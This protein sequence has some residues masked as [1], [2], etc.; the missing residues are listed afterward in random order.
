MDI[1]KQ[2]ISIAKK[3]GYELIYASR[4]DPSVFPELRI[5]NYEK[6]HASGVVSPCPLRVKLISD[7]I[8]PGSTVLDVGCGEGLIAE[9]ISRKKKVDFYG[10]DVSVHA[11][12]EF[13]KKGFKGEV[14]DIEAEGLNLKTRY[15]YI[16]FVEVLE[17]IKLPQKVLIEACEQARKGVI[18]T[19][20]NSAFIRWRSQ[21]L[22]GYFPRQSFTHLHFWS[23]DDFELFLKA[24]DLRVLDFKPDVIGWIDYTLRNLLASQQC[25]LIA[26]KPSKKQR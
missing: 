20:P 19:L 2:V 5:Y 10:I 7:W 15:D 14:R 9:K 18:V 4:F 22:R 26:P 23:I 13:I 24:L 25:W 16:L 11:I 1:F 3:I 21:M 12:S 8:E 17:H 6:Y